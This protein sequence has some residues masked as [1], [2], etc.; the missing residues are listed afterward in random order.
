[1]AEVVGLMS[2]IIAVAG[3]AKTVLV[4]V[5]NANSWARDL[6]TVRDELCRSIRHVGFAA[7]TIRI[8]QHTLRGYCGS[9]DITDQSTVIH[10]L[11]AASAAEYVE[12]ECSAIGDHV[13]SLEN[14]IYSLLDIRWTPIV[15]LKW[16]ISVRDEIE[17]LRNKMLSIQTSLSLVLNCI[18]LEVGMKRGIKNEVEM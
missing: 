14:K 8:A 7:N 15:T 3:L 2:S 4:F 16:R 5:K 18:N 6:K 1:M 11:E 9:R 17:D 12:T 10:F 13:E